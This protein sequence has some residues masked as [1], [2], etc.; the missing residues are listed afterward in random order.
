MQSKLH[1]FLESVTNIAIGYGVAFISQ[2][3]VFPLV[4]VEAS[5]KQ[6]LLI[7]LYFT[8]IS[9]TRSYVIRRWFTKRTE[10]KNV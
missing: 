6:N 1:S 2:L 3:I 4:G 8:L 10:K 9:L 7:G 5:I